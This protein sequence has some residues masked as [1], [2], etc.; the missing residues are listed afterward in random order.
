MQNI[1]KI[2]HLINK[3]TKNRS[4]SFQII[5]Q[6]HELHN[7]K[8]SKLYFPS[9]HPNDSIEYRFEYSYPR[10]ALFEFTATMNFA[11][12]IFRR[13]DRGHFV[14]QQGVERGQR[15]RR[16]TSRSKMPE[17]LRVESL[18]TGTNCAAG[19]RSA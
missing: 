16:L 14:E 15:R 1:P 13:T 12:N 7:N 18:T 5:P 8:T 2:F 9:L 3:T 6:N 4:F 10:C 17:F 11:S 19:T